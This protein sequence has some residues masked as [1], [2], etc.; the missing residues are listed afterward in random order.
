MSFVPIVIEQ[1][2]RTERAYDIYSRLLKDRIVFVG[3]IIEDNL[4]NTVVAQLLHLEGEDPERDIYMYINSPGGIISAGLAIYDTMQYIKPSVNTICIGQAASMA[5]VLLAAG[6][7]GKRSALPNSRIM[8][9][10]PMG[11][12]QGQAT[13]IEI[14][15][16]EIL[17]LRGRMN[18]ILHKH[19]GQ[20]IEKILEDTER[21]YFMS[22]EEAMEYG[23][24]DEVI[25]VR[26]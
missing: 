13:D 2:G 6:A 9:H 20:S 5:A 18:E 7:S 11:G 1:V 25:S 24:I 8:I 12:A 21:N 10:Q 19:S 14:Q 17:Y 3:G 16:K 15:A 26:K 23:I 22:A 4:A